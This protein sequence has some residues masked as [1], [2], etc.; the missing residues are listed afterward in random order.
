MTSGRCQHKR[1]ADG[2][3]CLFRV[4]TS[5]VAHCFLGNGP[6][7]WDFEGGRVRPE[8]D[9]TAA[10]RAEV[11]EAR[12]VAVRNAH[13]CQH[14]R[15]SAIQLSEEAA[16]MRAEVA[17][18]ERGCEEREDA[19]EDAR[20]QLEASK[21]DVER[22]RSA[23]AVWKRCARAYRHDIQYQFDVAQDWEHHCRA[24]EAR[25]ADSNA[26]LVRCARTITQTQQPL[27]SDL[28][29]YFS[30]QPAAPAL[31]E[32]EQR[33]VDFSGYDNERLRMA[34]RAFPEALTELAR[35]GLK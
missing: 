20:A 31:T 5:E 14:L 32:A 9:E 28:D 27:R 29:S 6:G 23:A 3:Q 12:E 25:L 15:Q 18:L 33:V 19:W 35:R 17:R 4:H 34:A 16:A 22:L 30:G 10:L 24:A 13:D 2:Q 7:G 1:D 11:N 21:S 8:P 26:L